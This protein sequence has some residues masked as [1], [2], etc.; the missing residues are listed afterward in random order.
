MTGVRG[1][2]LK[3]LAFAAVTL[4]L[5][6][7]LAQ[8]L[9]SFGFGGR[10]TY[11]ARFTD[12]TGLLVGDD[13]RVAGVKVGEVTAI[14]LVDRTVAELE[15]TVDEQVVVAAGVRAKIRYRDLVGQRYLALA[16]GPGG[17]A[18]LAEHG[19]IPLAQTTPALDLTVVF[20]GFRPLF[21][22]LSPDEVNGF[23]YEIIKMLQ[24][25]GGTVAD[26]LRRT[27][28]LTGT[29]ADRD[30]VIGRVITNL[31]TVLGTLDERD[32]RLSETVKQ[33][34]LLVSGLA[35][36]RKAVGDA[37]TNLSG[38]ADAT[39]SLLRDARP[40]VAADIAALNKL[41]GTLIDNTAVIEQTLATAPGRL[42][43][44]TRTASYGSWFNFYLCDFDGRVVAA[45]QTLNPATLNGTSAKC[46][47]G[48]R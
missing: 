48:G 9:G 23:A 38:L 36:D 19:L 29:L 37:L 44:L 31:N 14:R 24:G 47:G 41:A 10:H 43:A 12:V 30:E 5:T 32:A 21:A 13:V 27:A 25:E 40:S 16:E 28:S 18:P 46:S 34:Q 1:P 7:A 45:G 20:N 33:L 26:L 4:V 42:D 2:L 15:F 11:R 17:T 3:L 39:S 35:G 8:T 22:G 6:G